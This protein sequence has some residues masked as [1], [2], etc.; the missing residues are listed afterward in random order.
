MRI[1]AGVSYCFRNSRVR[2]SAEILGTP[3]LSFHLRKLK[4]Q[5]ASLAGATAKE[6][7]ELLPEML[8]TAL[9]E[10]GHSGVPLLLSSSGP[11]LP[12]IG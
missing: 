12:S 5:Q 7:R 8:P 6:E 9:E 11:L 3:S 2:G 10:E 1:T 4:P